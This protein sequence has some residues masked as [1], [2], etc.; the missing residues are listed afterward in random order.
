MSNGRFSDG[1]M[2]GALA[3]GALVFLLG[4]KRGNKVLKI[5]ME[6]GRVGLNELMDEIEDL[7][8]EAQ[9][10]QEDEE[11]EEG[12]DETVEINSKSVAVSHASNGNSSKVKTP[13]SRSSKRFFKKSK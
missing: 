3:G 11:I 1:L 9:E 12:I 8:N 4:T 2:I 13:G 6:E 7:K 10:I 5:I